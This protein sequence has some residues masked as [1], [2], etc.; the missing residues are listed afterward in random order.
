MHSVYK[1]TLSEMKQGALLKRI[2]EFQLYFRYMSRRRELEGSSRRT[3]NF[4]QSN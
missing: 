3:C 2:L 1:S 4:K